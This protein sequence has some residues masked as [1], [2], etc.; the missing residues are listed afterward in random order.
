MEKRQVRAAIAPEALARVSRFFNAG[1]KDILREVFQNARRAG[2]RTITLQTADNG[3]VVVQDNGGGIARAE[4]LLVFGGSG[5]NDRASRREDPAGMG[6]YALGHG[7]THVAS[8]RSGERAWHMTL[9]ERVFSGEASATV[10]TDDNALAPGPGTEIL[11]QASGNADET[12]RIAADCARFLDVGVKINGVWAPQEDF[13]AGCQHQH[14]WQGLQI[15]AFRH[16]HENVARRVD[17]N[18]PAT[19][20]LSWPEGRPG[21]INVHGNVVQLPQ[22]PIVP[23][24][25]CCWSARVEVMDN[26][27]LQL[28]LPAG[29]QIVET[30]WVDDLREAMRETLY[31]TIQRWER[32]TGRLRLPYRVIEEAAK[33]R[34]KL[35]GAP[36]EL[37]PYSPPN[38]REHYDDRQPDGLGPKAAV[39]DTSDL[40]REDG[41]ALAEALKRDGT[42]AERPS[43]LY[44]AEPGYKGYAWYDALPRVRAVTVVIR[45]ER[46]PDGTVRPDPRH[47]DAPGSPAA[48]IDVVLEMA[49]TDAPPQQCRIAGRIAFPKPAN[50]RT[51]A[52]LIVLAHDHRYQLQELTELLEDTLRPIRG[53]AGT[54]PD[55]EE[56]EDERIAEDAC[57]LAV[58][59]L[60]SE[61]AAAKE[62]IARACA[63]AA[64]Y[65]P[66][67][68]TAHVSLQL[69][70]R[71]AIQLEPMTR[72]EAKGE[73]PLGTEG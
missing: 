35:R 71:P 12:C 58:R 19:W 47:A 51:D 36:A 10:I 69:D 59:A 34:I 45:P 31:A 13:L 43:G 72:T 54:D 40:S 24:R 27:D 26:A 33:R 17:P 44:K 57:K 50:E 11:F 30:P 5:W 14:T 18:R 15:A 65:V 52:I 32:E 37:V 63:A 62:Q 22:N 39:M 60:F 55:I 29:K 49:R 6:F 73:K 21:E 48:D 68:Y 20:H 25:D 4:D 38:G 67:G 56:M 64:A 2:A 8:R 1:T 41:H 53:P 66:T 42:E 16:H 7:E 46:D 70:R 23:E 28:T 61:T 3:T 9:S